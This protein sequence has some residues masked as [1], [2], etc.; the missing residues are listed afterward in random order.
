MAALARG[1][2]NSQ[3]EA[4]GISAA[5]HSGLGPPAEDPTKPHLY[6]FLAG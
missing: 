6:H 5:P 1:Q 2:G 3:L 4:V